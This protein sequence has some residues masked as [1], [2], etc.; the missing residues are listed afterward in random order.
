MRWVRC[1]G[2]D[3]LAWLGLGG[4]EGAWRCVV[5]SDSDSGTEET[6]I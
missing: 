5:G 2:G 1:L 6:L 3:G 4:G